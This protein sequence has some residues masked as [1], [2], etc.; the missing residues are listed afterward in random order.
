MRKLAT[1]MLKELIKELMIKDSARVSTILSVWETLIIILVAI[2]NARETKE[3]LAQ[4]GVE[5]EIVTHCSPELLCSSVLPSSAS[6][7]IGTTVAAPRVA[8]F[9]NIFWRQNLAMLPRTENVFL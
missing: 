4:A 7:A 1:S 5:C 6:L 9:F 3:T 8:T 2:N